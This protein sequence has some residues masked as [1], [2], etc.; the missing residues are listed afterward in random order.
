MKTKQIVTLIVGIASMVVIP[1]T[2]ADARGGGGGG[3][4]F[5]GG[6]GFGGGHFGGTGG[7]RG[8]GFGAARGGFGG[9]RFSVPAGHF[10]NIRPGHSFSSIGIRHSGVSS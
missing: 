7:G 6:G 10:S 5:H 8:G 9:P 1:L 3:G 4:G 2:W